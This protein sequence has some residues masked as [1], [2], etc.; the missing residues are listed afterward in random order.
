MVNILIQ[1]NGKIRNFEDVE[2]AEKVVEQRKNKDPWVVIDE[3]LKIWAAKAPDDEKAVRINVDEYKEV[4]K[5]KVFA[6]T[7][8]GK[9]QER[10]LILAFPYSL[11]QM[12]RT[13]YKA[14][15]LPFDKKFYKE[16]AR[17]Y[18]AFKIPEK[19]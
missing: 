14:D 18:P 19:V 3:L 11:Q 8:H 2:L 6:Q 12:I 10:R 5:D 16:F 1:D 7:M 17:R 4:Q 13:Q 9:D 15:V